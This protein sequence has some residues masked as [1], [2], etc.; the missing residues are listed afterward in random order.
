MHKT[1]NH[2]PLRITSNLKLFHGVRIR[3]GYCALLAIAS[4]V[5]AIVRVLLA[6][7][8]LALTNCQ[9]AFDPY[10]FLLKLEVLDTVS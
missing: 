3:L 5:L 8:V 10:R 1:P 4:R 6:H 7:A 9:L 2:N